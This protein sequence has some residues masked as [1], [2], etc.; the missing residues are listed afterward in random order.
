VLA[1]SSRSIEAVA[2]IDSGAARSV[3][4]LEVARRLG[5]ADDLVV[6]AA[7][8]L[9]VEGGAFN[10]WSYPSGLRCQV[11][12]QR[13]EDFSQLEPWSAPIVLTPAF[14]DNDVFLLG[15]EDF[16]AAFTITF[17]PGPAGRQFALTQ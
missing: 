7:R 17:G 5:L 2:L 8:L 6:D 16:F 1:S 11:L 12:R 15:R 9:G 3:F 10:T 13:A 14:S 4:P